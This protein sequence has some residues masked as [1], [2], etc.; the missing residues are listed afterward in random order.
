MAGSAAMSAAIGR[1]M[2]LRIVHQTGV[3]K[4]FARRCLTDVRRV[5]ISPTFVMDIP[6]SVLNARNNTDWH[7][8]IRRVRRYFYCPGCARPATIAVKITVKF[9]PSG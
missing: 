3:A 6:L 8:N 4:P 9:Y 5:A 2:V 1:M 7:R